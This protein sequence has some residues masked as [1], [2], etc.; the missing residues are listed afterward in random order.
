MTLLRNLRLKANLTQT[1]AAALLQISQPA[2]SQAES[3]PTLA[4]RALQAYGLLL[5]AEPDPIRAILAP[6]PDP[7]PRSLRPRAAIRDTIRD[8]YPAAPIVYTPEPGESH[9][10]YLA[11]VRP[12]LEVRA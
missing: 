11:R 2:L 1:Q 3:K 8:F 5:T 6:H 4:D 9:A 10:D 7:L 12:A